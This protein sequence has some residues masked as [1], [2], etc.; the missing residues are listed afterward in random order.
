[1]DRYAFKPCGS[2]PAPGELAGAERRIAFRVEEGPDSTVLCFELE[3]PISP[4]DLRA[5]RPPRVDP[6]KGVILSGRGPIWLYAFLAH[7]YHPTRWIAI[8]DPRL[9]A[10][11]VESH[12]PGKRVGDVIGMGARDPGG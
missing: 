5:I 7:H 10:V 12:D 9:G 1:M 4:G 3:G 11:V 8:F 2:P 6:K